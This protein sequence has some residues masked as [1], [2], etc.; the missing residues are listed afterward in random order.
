MQILKTK[1]SSGL[2]YSGILV[3]PAVKTDTLIL[4]IHGMTGDVYF[5]SF[6]PMMYNDYPKAGIAFLAVE[7]RGTHTVTLFD[8]GEEIVNI[9]NAYELFE[10]C[11]EDIQAWVSAASELGFTNIWLQG[12]SLGCAK[13]IYSLANAEL[14]NVKGIILL[15][16]ADMLGEAQHP[17]EFENYQ[18]M[19]AEAQ[20]LVAAGKPRQILDRKIWGMEMSAQSYLNFFADGSNVALFNFFKPELGFPGLDKIT[21]PVLSFTGTK[22]SAIAP[23]REPNEAMQM[24]DNALVNS[25]RKHQV[26]YDGANHDFEGFGDQIVS[27]VIKFIQS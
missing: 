8:R 10:D 4:H 13:I 15:S 21:M 7:H 3:E 26:V 2:R 17:D 20:Q 12:H 6:Y 19:L 9:G 11:V 24:L 5:N 18:Q 14:A 25:P 22:D 27:E 1:T 16:P 23:M